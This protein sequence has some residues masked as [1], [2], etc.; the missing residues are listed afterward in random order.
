[1]NSLSLGENDDIFGGEVIEDD[2]GHS[3]P[4]SLGNLD[5]NWLIEEVKF[6]SDAET[7]LEPSTVQRGVGLDDNTKLLA[8]LNKGWL[9]EVDGEFDLVDGW[10]DSSETQNIY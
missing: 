10:L 3:F 2:L 1:M 5:K 7:N 6:L 4:V 9:L 8:C